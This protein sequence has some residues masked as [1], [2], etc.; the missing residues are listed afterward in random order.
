MLRNI[1]IHLS[2][3]G[4]QYHGFQMQ[5]NK[6]TVQSLLQAAIMQVTGESV[7]VIGSGRTDAGVHARAQVA[8]VHIH[9]NLPTGKWCK[10][11]NHHLP[12]DIVVWDAQDVSR[13]FDAR[14]SA[15]RKTY[16]YTINY[17]RFSDPLRQHMEL[18][19]PAPLD[20][21]AMSEALPYFLGE[22]D[23]TS[24]SS[25]RNPK[26][27]K[28]RTIYDATLEEVRPRVIEIRITG[29]GFLYQM[30]RIMV[31]TLLVIGQH[32]RPPEE[33]RNILLAQDRKQAGPTAKAHGLILWEVKY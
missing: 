33:I 30:V 12:S 31:G 10:A 16:C 5:P 17:Q 13:T 26:E 23:F 28:V 29:N 24:F 3:K 21:T 15:K 7:K 20:V 19:H 6:Q 22:H 25:T 18:H 2:Y 27:N 9:S 4:S 14:K 11:L 32:K 8:N 1:C